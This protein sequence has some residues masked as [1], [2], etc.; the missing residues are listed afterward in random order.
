MLGDESKKEESEKKTVSFRESTQ[1]K[2]T[3]VRI[4]HAGGRVE[5][6]QNPIPVSELTERYPSMC[7]AKPQV[8]RRPHESILSGDNILS[9]GNKYFIVRSSTVEKLKRRHS[10]SYAR[11]DPTTLSGAESDDCFVETVTCARDFSVSDDQC[12][13]DSVVK[14]PGKEKK[15]QKFVPPIQRPKLWKEP[16]WEPSLVSIRELSQ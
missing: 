15:R 10:R 3:V 16:D 12:A 11:S 8:F 1:S 13:A 9:P 5:M 14:K 2:H 6:Y 7:V 4:V